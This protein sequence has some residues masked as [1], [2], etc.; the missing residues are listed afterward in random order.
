MHQITPYANHDDQHL[1][2]S[3]GACN[4][5]SSRDTE[6]VQ[7][8]CGVVRHPSQSLA[9]RL[10]PAQG[11]RRLELWVQPQA[12]QLTPAKVE[13]KG[14]VPGVRL[15]SFT[16]GQSDPPPPSVVFVN[17]RRST[18][19]NQMQELTVSGSRWADRVIVFEF[20]MYQLR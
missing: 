12:P 11:G 18:P 5:E 13:V 3:V 16:R 9:K 10:P 7:V 6:A 4:S 8:Q 14:S 17:A 2:W 15:S 19:Q 1:R 20:A